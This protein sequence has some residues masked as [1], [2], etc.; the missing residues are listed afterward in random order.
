[1]NLCTKCCNSDGRR[2][3]RWA[4]GGC[5]LSGATARAVDG[6]RREEVEGSGA[7]FYDVGLCGPLGGL[8]LGYSC[9]S[10]NLLQRI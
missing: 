5:G 1:V 8:L 2:G 9:L 6:R 10:K 7:R 3:T 4:G